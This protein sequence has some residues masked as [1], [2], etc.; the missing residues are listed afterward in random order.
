MKVHSLNLKILNENNI[1]QSIVSTKAPFAERAV[2]TIK[3][4][5]HARIEGLDLDVEKWVDMLPAIL[6]KYNSTKHSTTG[7]TPN[8][9][10]KED[11][12]LKVWLNIKNKAEFN[13]K[14]PPL[15]VGSFVRIYEQPK[16]KKGYKSVW[17]S[18][19]YKITFMNEN[20]YLIDDY[21][22]RKVFQRNELL[23]IDASEDKDS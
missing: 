9:A 8:E 4:M 11:N 6:R 20:G 12:K 18:K 7:V 13:R 22:K 19:V 10:N 23:K 2:Q 21:S 5:I 15:K 17:S 16:H 3:N 1:R 14:Y